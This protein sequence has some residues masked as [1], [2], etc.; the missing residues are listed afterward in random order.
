MTGRNDTPRV[1][2]TSA[3]RAAAT[4]ENLLA[5]FRDM[6]V[7]RGYSR[8]ERPGLTVHHAW[9][10][11]AMFQG[12]WSSSLP[13]ESTD[14]IIRD[15]LSW[16]AER[17]SPMQFW[18]FNDAV[19]PEDLGD[20][21]AQHGFEVNF[22]GDPAMVGDI[23]QMPEPTFGPGVKV[24]VVTDVPGLE[25]WG[26]A[27]SASYELP[28]YLGQSWVDASLDAGPTT[29]PWQL[30]LATIDGVPLG[31]SM[32]YCGAGVAG[33]FAVGTDPAARGRGLG[34]ALTLAPMRDAGRRGY[35]HGVLFASPMGQPIY[36]RLGFRDTGRRIRR[37]LR[38][39]R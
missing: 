4:E 15:V 32:L 14:D 30:Y 27:F 24:E 39:A 29:S 6:S 20:R 19:Q 17:Q 23:A 37:Y 8:L 34:A 38:T 33:L 36:E 26:D 9:P 31:T 13:S 35:H 28:K 12:A 11:N 10:K 16:F 3:E 7:L 1:L 18:W 21:L 22:E 25:S 5:L 2:Q